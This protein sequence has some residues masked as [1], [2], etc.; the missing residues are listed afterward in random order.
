MVDEILQGASFVLNETYRETRFLKPP[1][2]T[3]AVFH[4]YMGSRGADNLNLIEEHEITV[5]LYE[6]STDPDAEKRIEEQLDERGV[7][8]EKQPRVWIEQ[9]QL[10]QVI[11]EFNYTKKKGE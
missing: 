9:E 5:E 4:D 7:E 6:Y 2:D 10:Y 3:Y 1:K 8:Y 11:Y